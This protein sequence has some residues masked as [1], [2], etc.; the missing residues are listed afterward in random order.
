MPPTRAGWAGAVVTGLLVPG[1]DHDARRLQR[2]SH[3]VQLPRRGADAWIVGRSPGRCRAAPV[4]APAP[5]L[6]PATLRF[7]AG[8]RAVRDSAYP[9]VRGLCGRRQRS[10]NPHGQAPTATVAVLIRT[11][12]GL[13]SSSGRWAL[14]PHPIEAQLQVLVFAH[15]LCA[16]AHPAA[17]GVGDAMTVEAEGATRREVAIYLDATLPHSMVGQGRRLREL[18][19]WAPPSPSWGRGCTTLSRPYPRANSVQR[20]GLG[21]RRSTSGSDCESRAVAPQRRVAPRRRPGWRPVSPGV[22]RE[23]AEVRWQRSGDA[24]S[25]AAAQQRSRPGHGSGKLDCS[26]RA[27]GRSEC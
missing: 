18:E 6:Q 20:A 7:T 15:S 17:R 11:A 14:S 3:H 2:G 8:A 12:M 27:P 21:R 24:A 23:R 1:D 16:A 22:R 26:V 9:H 13:G 5:G 25:R 10:T 4:R 19:R